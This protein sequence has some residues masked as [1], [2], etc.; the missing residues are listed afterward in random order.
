MSKSSKAYK[1]AA[2]KVDKSKLYSPLEAVELAKENVVEEHRFDRRG[3]DP[4]GC[5]PA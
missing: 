1:A 4:A 5:R 2:E 3:R